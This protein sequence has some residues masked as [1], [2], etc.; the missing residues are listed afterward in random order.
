MPT[1]EGT[2]ATYD[3]AGT[4]TME[5]LLRA[6]MANTIMLPKGALTT[7]SMEDRTIVGRIKGVGLN[8]A[9][10]PWDIL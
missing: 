6:K 2:I 8:L 10:L 5:Q 1:Q 9:A 4:S 7:Q 3:V